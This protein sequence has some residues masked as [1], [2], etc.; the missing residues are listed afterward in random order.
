MARSQPPPQA[1][2]HRR[3]PN[4]NEH[5]RRSK[6]RDSIQMPLTLKVVSVEVVV[7]MLGLIDGLAGDAIFLAR[8]SA[9]IHHLASLGTKRPEAIGRRH[10]DRL[11]ANRASHDFRNAK[12]GRASQR[13]GFIYSRW[14]ARIALSHKILRLLSAEI[15]CFSIASIPHGKVPSGCG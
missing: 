2:P 1:P 4:S 11:L 10:I 9:E 6:L 13:A 8:P 5:S 15:G 3:L 12:S 14:K 7:G